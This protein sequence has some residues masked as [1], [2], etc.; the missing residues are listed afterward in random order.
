MEHCL[1]QQFVLIDGPNRHA[2][3]VPRRFGAPPGQMQL[4]KQNEANLRAKY[5]ASVVRLGDGSRTE[6]FEFSL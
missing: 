2:T 6:A 4:Q 5:L 3:V 1:D